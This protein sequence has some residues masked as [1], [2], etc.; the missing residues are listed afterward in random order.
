MVHACAEIV[1]LRCGDSKPVCQHRDR[2]L[3]A[4]TQ[5]SDVNLCAGLHRL[6]EHRHG[7][8]VV[9]EYRVRAVFFNIVANIEH[10]RNVAQRTEYAGYAPRVADVRVHAVLFG[11]L[12]VVPPDVDVAVENRT[13]HAVRAFQRRFSI[14]CSGDFRAATHCAVDLF[15]HPGDEREPLRVYVHERD[16]RVRKCREC[17]KI[18]HEIARKDKAAR[19]DK[20][21]FSCHFVLRLYADFLRCIDYL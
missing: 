12:N 19:A 15:D 13:E 2:S 3:Y 7:I 21:K 8:R 16:L 4:V 20:R 17:Q 5:S 11:N 1:D 6:A 18:P 10:Q 14:E 9:E